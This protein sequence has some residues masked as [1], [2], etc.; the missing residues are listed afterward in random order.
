MD[1][2]VYETL[3]SEPSLNSPALRANSTYAGYCVRA[4]IQPLPIA[5]P[6]RGTSW[7]VSKTSFAVCIHLVIFRSRRDS[8]EVDGKEKGRR[9]RGCTDI[10]NILP[11]KALACDVSLYIVRRTMN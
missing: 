1:R 6:A 4:S 11:G 3:T 2:I 8:G 5:I 7:N 9:G 10:R